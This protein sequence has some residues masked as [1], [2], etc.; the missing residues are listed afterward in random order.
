VTL[1]KRR[2][3]E[4][5]H[6]GGRRTSEKERASRRI[7]SAACRLLVIPSPTRSK[8]SHKNTPESILLLS[9]GLLCTTALK[10]SRICGRAVK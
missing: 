10:L 4:R 5:G 7:V 9:G 6:S 8:C 1:A 2:S 3:S